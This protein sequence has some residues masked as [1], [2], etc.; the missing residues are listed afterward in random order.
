ME[1]LNALT[2]DVEDYYHVSA[3]ERHIT[4]ERWHDF[5]SRVE[6]STRRLLDILAEADTRATFFVL[7]WVARRH[8]ELVRE[9]HDAGHELG[10]HSFWHRLVFELSPE[11][12]RNDLRDSRAVLEDAAGQPITAYRAPSFSITRR[13][14]WALEIL[15]EEGFNVDSSIFPIRHDRY[16]IPDANP[17][18][19]E[20]S[21][22]AG[23]LQEFPP[24]VV[25]FAR[26]NFPVSG[27]GYFRL[28][29]LSWTVRG[30]SRV[31][32]KGRPFMFYIHPWELDPDQPR[33]AAGSRLSRARHR[34]NLASTA[35]KLRRL[36]GR[37]RFGRM[38]ESIEATLR[39]N[40]GGSG[41]G[42]RC[43]RKATKRCE[44]ATIE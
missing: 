15:A 37:F 1:I 13:S 10:S 23:P 32:G 7:G 29:P 19:H 14:Q 41:G 36:L 2:V 18:L 22:P 24:S 35:E 4:R 30:L 8:P 12:F 38:D 20:I 33:L 17:H 39:A 34:V 40:N 43:L 28:Y 9:I 44:S 27:G 21:T 6:A 26:M 42:E 11:E 16:G 31:N 3:F 5:D 25:R